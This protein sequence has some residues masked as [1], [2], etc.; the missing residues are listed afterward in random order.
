MLRFYYNP[1]Y[2]YTNRTIINVSND[3]EY[4]DHDYEN[5]DTI[6]EIN[7]HIIYELAPAE[8]LPTYIVDLEPDKNGIYRR[9]F[10]SGITQLRTNKYQISLLR[11]VIS[12]SQDWKNEQAFI[13]AGT[14][15]DYCKYKRWELPFTNTKVAQQRFNINGANDKS[16]FFVFYV[17]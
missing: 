14:A 10:F 2:K 8:K 4:S 12:E 7:A 5:I 13:E 1:A 11:D 6:D 9:Y 3:N 16:S 15:T 17:N